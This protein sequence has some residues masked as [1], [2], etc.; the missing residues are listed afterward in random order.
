MAGDL[1]IDLRSELGLDIARVGLQS[2]SC[3]RRPG[4][5]PGRGPPGR[6]P[7]PPGRRPGGRPPPNSNNNGFTGPF[8]ANLGTV[9]TAGERRHCIAG[10]ELSQPYAR[11]WGAVLLLPTTPKFSVLKNNCIILLPHFILSSDNYVDDWRATEAPIGFIIVKNFS[12]RHGWLCRGPGCSARLQLCGRT[13]WWK[14]NWN[15]SILPQL[16]KQKNTVDIFF[17]PLLLS[18]IGPKSTLSWMYRVDHIST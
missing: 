3:G 5:G 13:P 14:M 11:G 4:R 15:S 2:S 12:N 1:E 8:G 7:P 10:K 16:N 17:F 9:A 18:V 6:R